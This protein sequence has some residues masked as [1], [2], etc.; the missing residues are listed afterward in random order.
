MDTM[1]I[2]KNINF[3]KKTSGF[4]YFATKRRRIIHIYDNGFCLFS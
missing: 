3:S 1:T 4:N 2:H